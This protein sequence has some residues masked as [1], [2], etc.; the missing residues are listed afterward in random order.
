MRARVLV[1]MPES[2]R[3]GWIGKL[4]SLSPSVDTPILANL[5]RHHFSIRSDHRVLPVIKTQPLERP[6]TH[7][8]LAT[9]PEINTRRW[10]RDA[11]VGLFL[12]AGNL[13]PRSGKQFARFFSQ[14]L[15][16]LS[17]SLQWVWFGIVV[18]K[19][20]FLRARSGRLIGK[21]E[22]MVSRFMIPVPTTPAELR[23]LSPWL[24]IT[25]A[26]RVG[27]PP[28]RG[29]GGRHRGRRREWVRIGVGRHC[30]CGRH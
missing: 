10:R 13:T 2:R 25:G 23:C 1:R 30:G 18:H 9:K 8:P 20:Y 16:S 15:C 3:E 6:E 22:R 12:G 29:R 24:W 27:C 14:R 5:L 28:C 11:T 21:G 7:P 17:H 4:H 19:F 26:D